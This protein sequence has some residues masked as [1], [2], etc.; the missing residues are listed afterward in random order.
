MLQ[1]PNRRGDFPHFIEVRIGAGAICPGIHPDGQH[2]SEVGI[3]L[4][5][6]N[7]G[8]KAG[9]AV[10]TEAGQNNFSAIK[11]EW[12]KQIKVG[13]L[14]AE[15]W[16]HHAHDLASDGI[17]MNRTPEDGTMSRKVPLPIAIAQHDGFRTL[18]DL[19]FA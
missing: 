4:R 19:I 1:R 9:D 3:H 14:D 18:R 8:F 7:A 11:G 17:D 12:S 5:E 16:R 13:V 15:A 6:G 10:I 2:A